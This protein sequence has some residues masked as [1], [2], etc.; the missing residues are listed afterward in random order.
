METNRPKRQQTA[1]E[2]ESHV[3]GSLKLQ[4][5]SI[6]SERQ[7]RLGAGGGEINHS[8]Q[9]ESGA[10]YSR[11]EATE[12]IQVEQWSGSKTN[13]SSKTLKILYS[14][15]RSIVKIVAHLEI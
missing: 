8:E 4:Q 11:E 10:N 2:S 9:S 6:G 1:E 7:G 14:N 3:A 13:G 12:Q 5:C 15:T